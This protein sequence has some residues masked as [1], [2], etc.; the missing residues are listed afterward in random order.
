VTTDEEGADE[1]AEQ[2]SNDQ[3]MADAAAATLWDR[4]SP[5]VRKGVLREI[6]LKD[7]PE[8]ERAVHRG[9]RLRGKK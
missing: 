1:M 6:S 2:G 3:D 8:V 4:M 9:R 5:A 7:Q